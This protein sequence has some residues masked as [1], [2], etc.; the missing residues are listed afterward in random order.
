[1]NIRHDV[2][3]Y[4]FFSPNKFPGK[5]ILIQKLQPAASFINIRNHLGSDWY[6]RVDSFRDSQQ[7][8]QHFEKTTENRPN[9]YVEPGI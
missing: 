2:Y 1:M 4:F 6:S 8:Y 5:N 7:N 3:I 9:K